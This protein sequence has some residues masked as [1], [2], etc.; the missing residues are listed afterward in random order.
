MSKVAMTTSARVLARFKASTTPKFALMALQ[1]VLKGPMKHLV[2]KRIADWEW[3][4]TAE[5][6]LDSTPSLDAAKVT[7]QLLTAFYRSGFD[8]FRYVNDRELGKA[9]IQKYGQ[10]IHGY[11]IDEESM[12]LTLGHNAVEADFEVWGDTAD[13]E[14]PD[15]LANVDYEIDNEVVR[16]FGHSFTPRYNIVDGGFG[17]DAYFVHTY[18]YQ[19]KCDF[20][21][22]IKANLGPFVEALAAEAAKKA[23]A[24]R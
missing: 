2:E 11:A 9:F 10:D 14:N 24:A 12:R 3:D 17:N 6:L 4:F 19:A 16:R 22:L 1:P 21:G 20:M 13:T 23:L 7:E 18:R 8:V 5:E 15:E